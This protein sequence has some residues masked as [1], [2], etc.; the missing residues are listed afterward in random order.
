MIKAGGA[1]VPLD[2]DYPEDR[3]KFMLRDSGASICLSSVSLKQTLHGTSCDV[4]YLDSE[5][6][7][8]DSYSAENP[9]EKA[10]ADSMA[11]II[12]TSG[13]T[14]TPKGVVGLHRG[15]INRCSWMW[16]TYP[17][18]ENE[19]CCLITKISFV[20]SIWEMFGPPLQGIRLVLIPE[21]V[22]QDPVQLVQ[23]LAAKRITRLVLVPSLLRAILAST[24]NIAELVPDLK[25]WITSGERLSEKLYIR[26]RSALPDCTLLNL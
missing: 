20:D 4:I 18:G 2:P 10:S 15:I 17:F 11:Y 21:E 26:F 3:V 1:I 19:V 7:C 13:S 8:Y 22:V 16:Q 23:K 14:G 9:P 6:Q 24:S 12:Y 25:L 5:E